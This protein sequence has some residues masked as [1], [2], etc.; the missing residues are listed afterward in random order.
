MEWERNRHGE[1]DCTFSESEDLG[2]KNEEEQ[3]TEEEDSL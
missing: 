1:E 3:G 2:P